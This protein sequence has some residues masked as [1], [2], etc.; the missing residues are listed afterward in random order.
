MTYQESIA[1]CTKLRD[2]YDDELMGILS[3]QWSQK[4]LNYSSNPEKQANF[5]RGYE[6]G[7]AQLEIERAMKQQEV[8]A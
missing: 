6:R 2:L 1:M 3:A 7:K 4:L 5:V 8:S